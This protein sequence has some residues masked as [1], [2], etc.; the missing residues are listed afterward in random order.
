MD[1]ATKVA[2]VANLS[3][4]PDLVEQ[5]TTLRQSTLPSQPPT[6]LHTNLRN[7]I[8]VVLTLIVCWLA[9]TGRQE[10]MT[11][12][13]AAFSVLMGALWGERA[14]LKVPGQDS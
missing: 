1:T 11:A 14:A 6:W 8:A 10:A 9:L 3:E 5:R 2:L 7:L 13:I 4:N 12:L